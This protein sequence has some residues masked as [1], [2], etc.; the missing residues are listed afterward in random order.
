MDKKQIISDLIDNVIEHLT[1]MKATVTQSVN[2]NEIELEEGIKQ[3]LLFKIFYIKLVI[4][5]IE[6]YL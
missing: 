5:N 2:E 3:I 4:Q 6:Y 1:E